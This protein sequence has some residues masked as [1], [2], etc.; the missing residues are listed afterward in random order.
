VELNESRK[1]E[2]ETLGTDAL[3]RLVETLEREHRWPERL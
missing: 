2:L 3:K 1:A